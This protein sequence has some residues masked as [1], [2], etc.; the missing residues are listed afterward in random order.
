MGQRRQVIAFGLAHWQPQAAVQKDWPLQHQRWGRKPK[1]IRMSRRFTSILYDAAGV[2][3]A[4]ALA[5]NA[6]G[7][8]RQGHP[9][10][11][12]IMS[13]EHNASVL[14]CYGNKIIRTPN[15]DSLASRGVVFES[16]YCNSPLCVPSRLSFTAGK[17]A[18]RVGAWSNNCRLPADS[19]SL[20]RMLNAAGYESFLCGKM[21]YDATCRYGFT[22]IGGNMNR[23]HMTGSGDR[24]PADK[25]NPAPGYSERF[26]DFHPGDNF[27]A[28]GARPRGDGRRAGVSPSSASRATS[29]SSCW[30]ATSPRISRSLCRS[31][32]GRITGTRCPC[33]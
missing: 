13:D 4:A 2:V 7:A 31:S 14:G 17:Y 28:H 9:N 12:V 24:R 18:S 21:H 29:R 5:I 16:C 30:Q 6:A 27:R 23:S 32:I 26:V 15:L 8:E 22:E 3:F 1:R 19:P 10:I 25:L 11:L 20:P 33:R